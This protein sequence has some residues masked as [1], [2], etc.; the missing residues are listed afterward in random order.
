[1]LPPAASIFAAAALLK[2]WA[3]T[4]SGRVS[5]PPPNTLIPSLALRITRVSSNNS[6]VTTVSASNRSS[7]DTFSVAYARANR[8]LLKPRFGNRRCNGVCPPSKPGP[9]PPPERAPCPLWPRPDVLPLPEPMPRPTRFARVRA[10]SPG[11]N[12]CSFI[13][14]FLHFD[15]V[16][17]FVHH[18]PDSRSVR[19]DDGVVQAAQ[20]EAANRV[21]LV[22]L[23]TDRAAF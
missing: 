5:S 9:L 18:A 4:V 13:S 21:F 6:G 23:T 14:R 20:S 10:P 16:A 15:Q 19:L 1:M 22:L 3:R 2:A 7:S 17:H 12:V 8:A 11:P